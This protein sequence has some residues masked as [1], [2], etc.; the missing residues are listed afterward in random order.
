[1]EQ[2]AATTEHPRHTQRRH[3][4]P[5]CGRVLGINRPSS[6]GGVYLSATTDLIGHHRDALIDPELY[7]LE[8]RCG[9]TSEWRGV[10]VVIG[11]ETRK[12]A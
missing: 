12:V 6:K 4:C 1:M 11:R 10:E 7:T 3:L 2:M 9:T 8:C 5:S